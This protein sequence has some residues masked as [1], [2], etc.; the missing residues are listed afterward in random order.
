[1]S[2][3]VL[4]LAGLRTASAQD[5]TPVDEVAEKYENVQGARS[6]SA[7]GSKMAF[8]RPAIRKTPVA[9]IAD[10]V[11]NLFIL[12]MLDAP[13]TSRTMFL[14]DLRKALEGYEYYGLFP[15]RNGEVEVYVLKSD[16]EYARELVIYNPAIFSLN[17]LSGPIPVSALMRIRSSDRQ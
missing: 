1:M 11:D 13:D 15:S 10:D 5:L 7:E 14:A 8:V 2:I 6:F 17:V 4:M 9:S 16:Q 3:A 12:R